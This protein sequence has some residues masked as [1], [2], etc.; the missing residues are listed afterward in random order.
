MDLS[1]LN[2][3][4][5]IAIHQAG[6]LKG[7]IGSNFKICHEIVT[8]H[9]KQHLKRKSD[10]Q[11]LVFKDMKSC[12][13][14]ILHRVVAFYRSSVEYLDDKIYYDWKPFDDYFFFFFIFIFVFVFF[15]FFFFLIVNAKILATSAT[16]AIITPVCCLLLNL[17]SLFS[18][19]IVAIS[20]NV[21]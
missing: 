3:S 6:A 14:A 20:T 13:Y 1:Q 7:T 18:Y 11:S 8:A 4:I 15:F 2:P 16:S 12:D 17:T 10:Q 5:I 21:S 19:L 9:T